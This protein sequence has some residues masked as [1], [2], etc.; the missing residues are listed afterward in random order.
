MASDSNRNTPGP[1][2]VIP[3]GT[4]DAE[5]VAVKRFRNIYKRRVHFD[6][7]LQGGRVDGLKIAIT[8]VLSHS[9][10]SRLAATIQGL[11]G[12]ELTDKELHEGIDLFSLVGIKCKV[13]VLKKTISTGNPHSNIVQVFK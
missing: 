11:L 12:R 8:A 5:L 2:G 6:F 7:V 13:V 9:R 4:Y 3:D 1:A 10:E